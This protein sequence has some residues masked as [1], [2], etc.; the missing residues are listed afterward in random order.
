MQNKGDEGK[1]KMLGNEATMGDDVTSCWR[2]IQ[3]KFCLRQEVFVT[4]AEIF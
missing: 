3:I 4:L 1:K 2:L